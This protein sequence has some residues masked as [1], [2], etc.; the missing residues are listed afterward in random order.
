MPINRRQFIKRSAGAVS[1]SLMAPRWLGNA[2]GQSLSD[3]APSRKVLVVIE[4]AGGNDGL[5]T[6]IPYSDSRYA[7]LRPTIGFRDADLHDS[8]GKSTIIDDKI[9][10]HPSMGKLKQMYDAGRVAIVLGVGYPDP[11]GSHFESADIWHAGKRDEDRKDG[12][13]GRYVESSLAGARGLTAAAIEDKLPKTFF[14]TQVVVP[15][16][17]NF[18]DFGI[19][20]DPDHPDNRDNKINTLLALNSRSFPSNSFVGEQARIGFDAVNGALQFKSALGNYTSTIQYPGDNPLADGLRKLAEII[21]TIP[22]SVLLYVQMGGF[23]NHSDQIAGGPN[24]FGGQHATLLQWFSD[25]VDAFYRDMV[26]HDLADDVVLLQWSEFGRRPNENKSV[27]TDHGTASCIFAIGNPV[28]GGIYGS[29]PSLAPLDLDDAENMKFAV[30]F[31]SI[32][33]TVLDRWL[34]GD[35][36]RVLGKQFDNLGFIR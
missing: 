13:L 17:P 27:G 29:Q 10:L 14:S 16:I 9:G 20:T 21:T 28:H 32:Y 25:A 26:E 23:D 18:D 8:Q 7:A 24:K 4:L 30:D 3:S 15:N 19:Q 34:G 6:V 22:E 2:F 1:V 12:W 31:R 36:N 35:S 5:N 33:S 11:S